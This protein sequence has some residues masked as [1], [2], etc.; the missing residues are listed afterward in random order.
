MATKINPKINLRLRYKKVN[1]FALAISLLFCVIV[2]QAFKKFEHKKVDR[3]IKFEPIE[4]HFMPPTIQSKQLPPPA[5]PAI[6]TESESENI[7]DDVTIDNTDLNLDELPEPPT[8]PQVENADEFKFILYNEPPKPAG[9]FE[10]IQKHLVYPEL[11]RKIGVWGTVIIQA[12][13]NE[14]GEV[15]NTKV[16]VSLGKCGCDEAAIAAIKAV[17][18]E[19]AKQRDMPVAVWINIPIRFELK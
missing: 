14:K 3:T 5:R 9:G 6:P 11:A 7:P 18:W 17:K 2:F 16:I 4:V 8:P 19:P 13:I 1:Q 12:K 15:I 10:A